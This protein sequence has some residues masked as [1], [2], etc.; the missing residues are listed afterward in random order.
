[1]IHK[2]LLFPAIVVLI[3][4]IAFLPETIKAENV[5]TGP[6]KPELT[7]RP[8]LMLT[9]D[10]VPSISGRLNREPYLTLWQRVSSQ[11]A[12]TPDLSGG[13][14]DAPREYSNANIAK[15]NA[16][17][18][19]INGNE[20][21]AEKSALILEALLYDFGPL[22]LDLLDYDIHV[23]EAIMLYCQTLD[24]LFAGDYLDEPRKEAI[25]QRLELMV[26]NAYTYFV[27]DWGFLRQLSSNNHEIKFASA[28]G[29]AAIA[30]NTS[31]HAQTWINYGLTSATTVMFEVQ[32]SPGGAIAEGPYYAMYSAVNHMPFFLSYDS[33]TGGESGNF[34][35][36]QCGPMGGSC[37]WVSKWVDNPL[38]DPRHLSS[39]EWGWRIRMPDGTRPPYDDSN[40]SGAFDALLATR[41]SDGTLA[42]DWLQAPGSPYLS[43]W[44]ADISADILCAYDDQAITP[45]PPNADPFQYIPESG[46][47]VFRSSWDSNAVFLLFLAENGQARSAG[48]GHEHPDPCT[49]QLYAYNQYLLIDSGYSSWDNS[50]AV[51]QGKNHNLLLVDGAGPPNIG[52][53][54]LGGPDAFLTEA[55]EA[56]GFQYAT[57]YTSYLDTTWQRRVLFVEGAY[58]GVVD[59][60]H[61]DN[62]HSYSLLFHT[63]AGGDAGGEFALKNDG[64]GMCN[65]N[66]CC[67]VSSFSPDATTVA[68]H[69]LDYH[70]L[71]YNE[72]KQ[73]EV[74]SMSSQGND[75]RFISAIL[76]AP[77]SCPGWR[78]SPLSY[79][80]GFEITQGPCESSP[81]VHRS[82]LVSSR[83]MSWYPSPPEDSLYFE[84]DAVLAAYV[85]AES[86][87]PERIFAS[88]ATTIR[89]DGRH[90]IDISS[91]SDFAIQKKPNL[92]RID[93]ADW[94]NRIVEISTDIRP[95]AV[96]SESGQVQWIYEN[97]KVTIEKSTPGA[98]W[99]QFFTFYS[100]SKSIDIKSLY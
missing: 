18:Y 97:G 20:T 29:I 85:P 46:D 35:Q 42:W 92:W 1:M 44:C 53:Q 51:R 61:S 13:Q 94:Q 59:D 66:A 88:D 67:E 31:D 47:A 93:L 75:L 96:L 57:A 27:V 15:A 37:E 98:V 78:A 70:G 63:L 4:S 30:L 25:W 28:L 45:A 83:D 17:L 12:R 36:R 72:M 69:Y 82:Y 49:I 86:G 2:K 41:L 77:V 7:Y 65:G 79:E 58:F 91:P 14:Y 8:R 6:F 50:G 5:P 74:L 21:A 71:H 40:L 84:T 23:A 68:S 32:T 64:A 43:E 39:L 80:T 34:L 54:G 52:P 16:F 22:S 19:L 60:I 48:S 3:V 26:Q 10:E 90:L 55:F 24:L 33:F 38:T 87:D 95:K 76:P 73:H 62:V 81:L 56:P 89:V 100:R 99:L 9:P 11:A